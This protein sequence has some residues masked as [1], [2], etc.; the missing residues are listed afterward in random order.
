MI[1][2]TLQNRR[3]IRKYTSQDVTPQLLNSLLETAFRASSME[4]LQLYSVI[5]TR[6]A[7][8]KK[9]LSAAHFG[10]PMVCGAP[11]ILTFCT[12]INRF[13]KW[14]ACRNA[15][16]PGSGNFLS[17]LNGSIDALLVAQTFATLAEEQGLG[18][19]YLGT[20]IYNPEQISDILRLPELVFPI[21]TLSVGYPDETPERQDRL[22]LSAIV[23]DETY[24]DYTPADIDT[25]YAAKEALPSSRHFVSI[26]NKETLAQVYADIRYKKEDFEAISEKLISLL[27]SKGFLHK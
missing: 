1:N 26:N 21:A 24:H 23:H 15:V 3:T 22:P 14:C 25:I 2:Q 10:Q 8:Q 11:V 4:N 27:R 20:S 5:V 6:D 12:D 17:F 18:I 7:E 13:D 19:C 16:K 9:R